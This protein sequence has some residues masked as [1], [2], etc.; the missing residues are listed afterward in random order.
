MVMRML[1]FLCLACG[2]D[3]AEPLHEL[4]LPGRD[5]GFLALIL[6]EAQDPVRPWKTFR[7]PEESASAVVEVVGELSRE[8]ERQAA[9]QEF[10]AWFREDLRK[11]LHSIGG[12][13]Q[14]TNLASATLPVE[15]FGGNP[16][17][18]NAPLGWGY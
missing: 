2:L 11:Y 14:P 16:V 7:V 6:Q 15:R 8:E 1:I 10:M 17:P 12:P 3:A 5:P 13:T 18:R 9:F 4:P